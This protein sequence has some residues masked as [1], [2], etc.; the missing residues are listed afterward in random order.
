MCAKDAYGDE[1]FI[2]A[3]AVHETLQRAARNE[4]VTDIKFETKI[5]EHSFTE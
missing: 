1:E 3:L 5:N 4:A 2:K